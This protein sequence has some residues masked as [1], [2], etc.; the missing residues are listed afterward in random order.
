MTTS[1]QETVRTSVSATTSRCRSWVVG[2]P[3]MNK[4]KQVSSDHHQMSLVGGTDHVTYT[5]MHLMLPTHS[6]EQTDACENITFPQT[7]LP[8]VKMTI[9]ESQR[10]FPPKYNA[11][12]V[13]R[14]RS[15]N[16]FSEFKLVST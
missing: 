9:G 2:C 5:M 15:A 7:Y 12:I 10:P 6:P 14:G 1:R 13:K 3:R 11:P 16:S 8:A 4:F